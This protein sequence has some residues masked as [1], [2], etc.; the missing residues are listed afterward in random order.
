MGSTSVL[1]RHKAVERIEKY[2]HQGVES[3]LSRYLEDGFMVLREASRIRS[4]DTAAQQ[5]EGE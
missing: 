1:A 5:K 2:L 3:L 4:I